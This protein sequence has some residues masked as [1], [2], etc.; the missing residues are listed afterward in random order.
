MPKKERQKIIYEIGDIFEQQCNNCKPKS[1]LGSGKRGYHERL[2]VLCSQCEYD[3]QLKRLGDAL[4]KAVNPRKEIEVEDLSGQELTK[5]AYLE[6]KL[7]GET[8]SEIR[9]KYGVE[10]NRFGK[11]KREWDLISIFKPGND[12]TISAKKLLD[13]MNGVQAT[14]PGKIASDSVVN[15]KSLDHNVRTGDME[16][17]EENIKVQQS[18]IEKPPLG[19]KPK[20][21]WVEHRTAE[22]QA[23][24]SRFLEVRSEIPLDWIEELNEHIKYLKAQ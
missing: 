9:R 20:Y 18:P 22:I 23:A 21:I 13:E 5:R 14:D 12:H 2:N 16:I 19:L 10:P 7:L 8:D 3:Q 6:K 24:V 17:S 11:L 1:L 4:D 15:V